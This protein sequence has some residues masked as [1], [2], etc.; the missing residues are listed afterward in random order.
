[1]CLSRKVVSLK[2]SSK[3]WLY[4]GMPTIVLGAVGSF[5]V[6]YF[7]RLPTKVASK[8][9]KAKHIIYTWAIID[10]QYGNVL[11]LDNLILSNFLSIDGFVSFSFLIQ[12]SSGSK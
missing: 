2:P 4:L 10:K 1:M 6:Y 7:D 8:D 9:F 5:W 11:D 12:G 3:I